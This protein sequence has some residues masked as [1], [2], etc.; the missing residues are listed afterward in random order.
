MDCRIAKAGAPFQ[1]FGASG[2][3]YS[4]PQFWA[5]SDSLVRWLRFPK[6]KGSSR[7]V[8]PPPRNHSTRSLG[9]MN[10]S[11]I[12]RTRGFGKRRLGVMA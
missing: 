8:Q 5:R 7:G 3:I 4:E 9:E 10:V 6:F 11:I 12:S 1:H 2:R